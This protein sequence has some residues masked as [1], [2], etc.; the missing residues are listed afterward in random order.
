LCSRDLLGLIVFNLT[1]QDATNFRRVGKLAKTVA[2]EDLANGFW[3]RELVRAMEVPKAHIWKLERK[4]QGHI[5][6]DKPPENGLGRVQCASCGSISGTADY[7][8]R[9]S[10]HPVCRVNTMIGYCQKITRAGSLRICYYDRD[11]KRKIVT[12]YRL[13]FLP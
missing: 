3:Q 11:T 8:H 1:L 13:A 9:D 7:E 5:D 12:I 6:M 2:S 4:R 10:S